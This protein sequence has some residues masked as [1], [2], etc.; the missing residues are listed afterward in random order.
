MRGRDHPF[1]VNRQQY[2]QPG[3]DYQVN[4]RRFRFYK[5]IS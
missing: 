1:W 3:W 4:D 5:E 2:V